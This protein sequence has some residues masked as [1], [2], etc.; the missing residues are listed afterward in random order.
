M[1]ILQVRGL[2]LVSLGTLNRGFSVSAW[3]WAGPWV[4]CEQVSGLS[5]IVAVLYVWE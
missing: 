5:G 1:G 4:R 3:D 2:F